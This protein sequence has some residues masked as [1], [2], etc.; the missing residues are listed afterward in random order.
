MQAQPLS[1]PAAR[2]LNT[3]GSITSISEGPGLAHDAGNLLGALRLYCDLLDLPGVLRP[4]HLHYARELRLL[5]QRSGALINRLLEGD[6]RA[7]ARPPPL[8]RQYPAAAM[9]AFSPLLRSL[10]A[11]EATLSMTVT[12]GL[13]VLPFATE[14]L[15]RIL[16]NLTRNAATALRSHGPCDAFGELTSGKIHIA[17]TGDPKHLYLTVTDNGPGMPRVV[18]AAFLKPTPLPRGAING[19]GHRVIHDLVQSTGGQLAITVVPNQGT[20]VQIEWPI[21]ASA[22]SKP[23]RRATNTPS[24]ITGANSGRTL[25]LLPNF[26]SEGSHRKGSKISC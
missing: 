13:P 11:P 21:T 20:T 12:H 22:P 25:E 17:V 8:R 7:V 16:V 5:A 14:V 4:E 15:E 24:P 6:D 18:V 1:S 26:S 10:A 9:R 2:N 3:S 19:L 23:V